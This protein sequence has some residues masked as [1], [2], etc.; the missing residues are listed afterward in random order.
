MAAAEEAEAG[1]ER[2]LDVEIRRDELGSTRVVDGPVAEPSAGQVLLRIDRFGL[3]T[4]NITFGVTGELLGY[5]KL[6]PS[7]DVA[8]GRVPVFGY[9]DV[10][11]LSRLAEGAGSHGVTELSR[12]LSNVSIVNADVM[13]ITGDLSSPSR[14]QIAGI[15]KPVR[16]LSTPAAFIAR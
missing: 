13:G 15:P 6:F 8:W 3:S 12:E 16:L 11:V 10:V 14:R 7:V 1:D 4:N 9:A 5:W 2:G